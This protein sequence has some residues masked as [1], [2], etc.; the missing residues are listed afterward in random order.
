MKSKISVILCFLVCSMLALSMSAIATV[1]ASAWTGSSSYTLGSLVD[2][3]AD[4]TITGGG[5]V[6]CEVTMG[7]RLYGSSLIYRHSGY[8][9]PGSGGGGVVDVWC[10]SNGGT[11]S[12]DWDSSEGQVGTWWVEADVV[13]RDMS[14][15]PVDGDLGIP[16]YFDLTSP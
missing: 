6:K 3:Y 8:Y 14:G 13:L 4:F 12:Y 7:Y 1:D 11:A 15:D 5:W 16:D 9:I 10:D 2:T